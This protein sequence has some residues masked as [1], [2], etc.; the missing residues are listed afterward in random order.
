MGKATCPM[1][2]NPDY[3]VNYFKCAERYRLSLSCFF[4]CIFLAGLFS[5]EIVN[6]NTLNLFS[7]N[8]KIEY[9]VDNYF[10]GQAG[11]AEYNSCSL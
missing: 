2:A 8:F 6:I 11:R 4:I 10:Q 7:I 1:D 3:R 5:V 9:H